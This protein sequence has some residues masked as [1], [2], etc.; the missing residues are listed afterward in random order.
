MLLSAL[1][2]R[3]IL[4]GLS[5]LRVVL[6]SYR[7]ALLVA[8]Y[9][10]LMMYVVVHFGVGLAAKHPIGTVAFLSLIAA[11]FVALIQALTPSSAWRSAGS[12]PSRS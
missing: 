10:V 9:Q 7:G 4:D 5:A 3:P 12:S 6:A 1:Q 11:T 2:T 8:V